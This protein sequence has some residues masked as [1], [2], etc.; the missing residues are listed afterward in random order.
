MAPEQESDLSV[1]W[2]AV[3]ITLHYNSLTHTTIERDRG[4]YV[5]KIAKCRIDGKFRPCLILG[6][7]DDHFRVWYGTSHPKAEKSY[8]RLNRVQR[9]DN[10]GFLELVPE[11]IRWIHRRLK[12]ETI[13]RQDREANDY[14][15]EELNRMMLKASKR[16]F[17]RRET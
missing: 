8:I 2:V 3:F 7:K 11:A 14:V 5:E 1:G 4:N 16:S 15:L 12:F 17:Q 13:G 6:L 10:E 9:L